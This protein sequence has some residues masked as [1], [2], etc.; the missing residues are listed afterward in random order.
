M[1]SHLAP[2]PFFVPL[3]AAV[4]AR[5]IAIFIRRA[6]TILGLRLWWLAACFE[7]ISS[8]FLILSFYWAMVLTPLSPVIDMSG[9]RLLGNV[10]ILAGTLLTVFGLLELGAAAFL[11]MPGCELV[12]VGIYAH[13][14]RP[15]DAGVLIASIGAVLVQS[16]EHMRLWILLWIPLS[17]LLSELEEWELR[18][19]LPT[20]AAYFR[21]TPRYVS[22]F[23]LR[24]RN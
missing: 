17:I 13:L 22:A 18:G 16:S 2:A 15:M 4:I 7:L 8:V 6:A 12:T 23:R 10:M 9:S 21:R 5:L 1:L 19:R 20:A 24:A 11:V 3:L 14:R